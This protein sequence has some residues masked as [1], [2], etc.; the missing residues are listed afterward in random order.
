MTLPPIPN[1]PYAGGCLCG[2]V[3]Y[4]IH[5][6]P[7]AVNACHCTDC[8]KLTGATHLL[9]IVTRSADFR[10]DR[11][12]THRWRKRA[13]SGRSIA[14][15]RCASCGVR[16]WHEPLS[17]PEYVFVA[18]GTLDDPSWAV[19]TSHIWTR[20]ALPAA[21]IPDDVWTCDGQPDHRQSLFDAF[22][23]AHGR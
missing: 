15:V 19:P 8:H 12:E 9:M 7:L 14:I 11:G 21:R 5:A 10:H 4:S 18:V 13:D 2:Q 6:L 1:P 22:D 20:S 23:R 17:S 3:G 16:L